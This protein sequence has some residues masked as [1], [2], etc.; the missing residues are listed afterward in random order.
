MYKITTVIDKLEVP[1]KQ[2]SCGT[3][4]SFTLSTNGKIF[5]FGSNLYGQLGL[6]K[7]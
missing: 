5:T 4:N 7:I 1:I 3:E 2:I 6:E